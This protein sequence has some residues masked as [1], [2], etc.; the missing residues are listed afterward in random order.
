MTQP[1]PCDALIIGTGQAGKPLAGALAKAGWRVVVVEKGRVGGTCV[2]E[3]CTPT[4]TMVAS[5]R[6]A[7]LARRARDYG[8][9]AGEVTVDLAAVRARKRA[10]VDAWS[11]SSERGLTKHDTLELVPGVARFT[12]PRAV[13]V[14]DAETDGEG[15]PARRFA[16]EHVFI[17]AGTRTRIPDLPGLDRV[18]YL[19]STSIMELA[20]VPEH[21][22]VL[23]GGFIGLEFGQ[24][25]RRFGAAVTIVE[26]GARLVAREDEDVSDALADILRDEGID[27]RLDTPAERVG[28]GPDGGIALHLEG[29]D[30]VLGS[31][32]LVAIGRR[33]NADGLGLE[34]TGLEPDARGFIPVDDRC[35]TGVENVWA[36]GDITGAPPFTHISY[37]D[38]RVV[39]SQLLGDGSV[40]RA[41]RL[42][43]YVMFTD[44]QLGR[45]GLTEADARKQGR[46]IRVA[47]LPMERV[48][49]AVE[50]DET[51]GFM[52]AVVDA[53]TDRVL[54]AAIL[55]IEGGEVMSVLQMA[56]VADLPFTALRDGVFAHPTLAESLNNLFLALE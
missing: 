21:L 48:A 49:R 41:G 27:L 19:T 39:E 28:V 45:V 20:E 8:V 31:H 53:G 37:D 16:A 36:L 13:S 43:P 9:H 7:H 18:P 17:N 46:D 38:Y 14:H 47:K 10:I 35:R 30:T 51:R 24:M 12:G 26:G 56:M 11:G 52:K 22:I 44:P 40:T 15:V 50:T 34:H 5:A 29:G 4:K 3:G 1:E 32:L 42:L 54:G 6:V 33:S 55:G 23:G 25:F 2:V